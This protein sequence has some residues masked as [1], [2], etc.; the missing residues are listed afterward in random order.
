[1]FALL[2][3]EKR[4]QSQQDKDARD[5]QGGSSPSTHRR[6]HS[7]SVKFG[8]IPAEFFF[9][10]PLRIW[11]ENV[12]KYLRSASLG[13]RGRTFVWNTRKNKCNISPKFIT[14]GLFGT[15]SKITI[16]VKIWSKKPS[17][18]TRSIKWFPSIYPTGGCHIL[19]T[20]AARRTSTIGQRMWSH[21][22]VFNRNYLCRKW[23]KT[24]ISTKNF[25]QKF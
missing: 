24:K 15:R 11:A 16:I 1:M 3:N 9:S 17:A 5:G 21:D 20:R 13:R 14:C 19:Q 12:L 2:W 4:G 8:Y 6:A 7:A 18:S 22:A 10:L 25:C 23:L